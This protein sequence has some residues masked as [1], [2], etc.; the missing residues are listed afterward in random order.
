MKKINIDDVSS[1]GADVIKATY[2]L[3]YIA[4]QLLNE[5]EVLQQ[6]NDRLEREVN[7]WRERFP[8]AGFDGTS[9]VLSG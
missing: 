7:S 8:I 2:E 9:V 5:I 4:G 1:A 3:E 6:E